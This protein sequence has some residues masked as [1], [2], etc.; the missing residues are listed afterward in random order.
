M[1][2]SVG[3]K[4]RIHSSD[5]S[6]FVC[7][8]L[9]CQ[10]SWASA[11]RVSYFFSGDIAL[12]FLRFNTLQNTIQYRRG[13]VSLKKNSR[14]SV[15]SVLKLVIAFFFVIGPL[16]LVYRPYFQKTKTKRVWSNP[17]K[18]LLQNVNFFPQTHYYAFFSL[19][20]QNHL[21]EDCILH[22]KMH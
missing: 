19:K 9:F 8:V 4:G 14:Q 2:G 15:K 7:L 10:I 1:S 12:I 13:F 21:V 11:A 6:F 17:R 18:P 20:T 3:G 5:T 22:L 16:N